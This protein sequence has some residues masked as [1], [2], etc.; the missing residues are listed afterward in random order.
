M[1]GEQ[2]YPPPGKNSKIEVNCK[3]SQVF[4]A[5]SVYMDF[6]FCNKPRSG[7]RICHVC[8]EII[9]LCCS[10][11]KKTAEKVGRP[12]V[13]RPVRFRRPCGS[14]AVW[15]LIPV[16]FL[17]SIWRVLMC[18]RC[19][20]ELSACIWVLGRGCRRTGSWSPGVSKLFKGL[21]PTPYCS[22]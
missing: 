19:L 3:Y 8:A 12:W 14:K 11:L 20:Q 6:C 7:A 5:I 15:A 10:V 16:S 9:A 13:S 4:G 21:I 18:S 2:H 1:I 17:Y 22:L